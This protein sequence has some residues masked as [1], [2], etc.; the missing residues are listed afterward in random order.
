MKIFPKMA[1]SRQ[2]RLEIPSLGK[3][4]EASYKKRWKNLFR[5]TF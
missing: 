1:L 4:S 3:I 2:K 5:K